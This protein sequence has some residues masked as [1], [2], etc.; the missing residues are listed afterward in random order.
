MEEREGHPTNAE[1]AKSIVLSWNP[2]Y[3]LQSPNDSTST[4]LPNEKEFKSI[5][6][7]EGQR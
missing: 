4:S 1:R 3:D 6:R 5:Y 2:G 7:E